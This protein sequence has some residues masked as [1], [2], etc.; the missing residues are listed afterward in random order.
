MGAAMAEPCK[1]RRQLGLEVGFEAGRGGRDAVGRAHE[2]LL[3][4]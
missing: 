2:R 4:Y 1:G 3:R